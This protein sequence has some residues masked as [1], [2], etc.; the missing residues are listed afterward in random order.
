MYEKVP[1]LLNNL[2]NKGKN[3]R[4]EKNFLKSL[5]NYSFI[6]MMMTVT[7]FSIC[8]NIRYYSFEKGK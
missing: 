2:S 4:D 3:A 1:N 8:S 5:I 6:R 7:E